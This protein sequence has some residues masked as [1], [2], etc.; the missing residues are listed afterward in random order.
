MAFNERNDAFDFNTAL[1]DSK[2]EKEVRD[3]AP[4]KTQPYDVQAERFVALDRAAETK[5]LELAS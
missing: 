3:D 2:R 4:N 5:E 1:S